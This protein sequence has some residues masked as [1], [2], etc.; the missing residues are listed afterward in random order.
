MPSRP[1]R[2]AEAA[3]CV[4]LY[5]AAHPGLDR[6]GLYRLWNHRSLSFAVRVNWKPKSLV[7]KELTT[8]TL[9]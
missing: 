1:T 2:V 6:C 4:P 7:Y 5:V 3:E 8:E 9:S